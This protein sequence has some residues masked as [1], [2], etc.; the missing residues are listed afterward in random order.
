MYFTTKSE[1]ELTLTTPY[2][3]TL[4]FY[5]TYLFPILCP[6][7]YQTSNTGVQQRKFCLKWKAL[8]RLWSLCGQHPCTPV[9]FL[10]GA[11]SCL[12]RIAQLQLFTKMKHTQYCLHFSSQVVSVLQQ[13]DSLMA[14]LQGYAGIKY[15]EGPFLA[16]RHKRIPIQL[17]GKRHPL[18]D[19]V[20]STQG[21]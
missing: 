13:A 4:N 7:P 21:V 16:G 17:M 18:Q 19:A 14:L 20:L 5:R 2:F 11:V 6:A 8:S 12:T 15:Q 1:K 10:R 3:V 9:E